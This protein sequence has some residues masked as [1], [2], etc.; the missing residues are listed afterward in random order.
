MQ[1]KCSFSWCNKNKFRV[2][3]Q[4]AQIGNGNNTENGLFEMWCVSDHPFRSSE[5]TAWQCS[6]TNNCPLYLVKYT[7][8]EIVQNKMY[9]YHRW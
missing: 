1:D 3:L 9:N 4:V 2:D 7:S 5:P 8:N 6:V